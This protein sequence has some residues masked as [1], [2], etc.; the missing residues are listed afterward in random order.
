MVPYM[1]VQ[2]FFLLPNSLIHEQVGSLHNG[3]TPIMAS[4][5]QQQLK[6]RNFP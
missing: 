4:A 2:F 5:N 6:I 1:G 3:S